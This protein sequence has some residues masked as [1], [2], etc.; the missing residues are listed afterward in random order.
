MSTLAHRCT[1]Y[2]PGALIGVFECETIPLA[3]N[4]RLHFLVLASSQSGD[5]V[6]RHVHIVWPLRDHA[7][8][9]PCPRLRLYVAGQMR[10]FVIGCQGATPCQ[11]CPCDGR[12][13]VQIAHCHCQGP[14][15][16]F[17]PVAQLNQTGAPK[18][19]TYTITGA[20]IY[21]SKLKISTL[22]NNFTV[23][24]ST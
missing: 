7:I 18:A 9:S 6:C 1:Y 21:W 4:S 16:D 15:I 14:P 12:R 17:L 13:S 23:N 3:L 20:T 10:S 11:L 24:C 22:N 19:L 5:L 2:R 8:T